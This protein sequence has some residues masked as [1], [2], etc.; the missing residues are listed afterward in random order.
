MS[1][2]PNVSGFKPSTSGH[3]DTQTSIEIYPLFPGSALNIDHEKSAFE[4]VSCHHQSAEEI[5]QRVRLGTS[6]STSSSTNNTRN[7]QSETTEGSG[8][9]TSGVPDGS[10]PGQYYCFICEKDFRRPDI[11]S[12]HT[13]RHTG[14][15]P[16]KCED[17][18]RFFSRSDHLRT[19]RRTH[20]DEKPYHCCVCNY[21]A[22]SLRDTVFRFSGRSNLELHF[23]S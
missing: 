8:E 11:L 1:W 18:G 2:L 17:C 14:E 7:S 15:K 21:S 9:S 3:P 12:R 16:F 19:H 23:C 22:V 6:G 20:T 4:I 5:L 13:R 10:V